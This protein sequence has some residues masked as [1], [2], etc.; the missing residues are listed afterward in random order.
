MWRSWGIDG[1]CN[2][3]AALILRSEQS[4]QPITDAIAAERQIK[5]WSRVRKEA[6]I[7]GDF[8]A[9]PALSKRSANRNAD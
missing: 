2:Y 5:G 9:L 8:G 3:S 7:N 4:K 6:L 1:S